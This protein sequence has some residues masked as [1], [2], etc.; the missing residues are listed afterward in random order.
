M[1]R[2]AQIGRAIKI[3]YWLLIIGVTVGSLY[4]LKPYLQVLQGVYGGGTNIEDVSKNY[5]D[6]FNF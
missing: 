5:K 6:L 1:W 3:F 4:F 2:S